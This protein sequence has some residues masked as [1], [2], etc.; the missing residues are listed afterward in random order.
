MRQI[1]SMEKETR[2]FNWVQDFYTPQIYWVYRK[3]VGTKEAR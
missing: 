2:I 3:L 1:F